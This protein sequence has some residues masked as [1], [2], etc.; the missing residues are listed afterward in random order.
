LRFPVVLAILVAGCGGQKTGP[1]AG[2]AAID[3]AGTD[4]AGGRGWFPSNGAP[5]GEVNSIVV[6]PEFPNVIYAG[7]H[8]VYKS[9][10]AG[11]HWTALDIPS[12]GLELLQDL[13]FAPS[14]PNTMYVGGAEAGIWKSADRGATWSFSDSGF[15]IQAL[16]VDPTQ[17]DTV[18]AGTWEGGEIN[19]VPAG[20]LRKSED[21]GKTFSDPLVFVGAVYRIAVDPVDPAT[22][23]I[24]TADFLYKSTDG[25]AH[26]A[27]TSAPGYVKAI[28]FD[29]LDP[30]VVYAS[31]GKGFS[32][33]DD[34]GATWTPLTLPGDIPVQA[35][36]AHP[37]MQGI[38]YFG[39][40]CGGNSTAEVF[41]SDDGGK[42]SGA[43]SPV[44]LSVDGTV[45]MAIDAR[46]PDVVYAARRGI[47]RSADAGVSWAH[48]GKGINDM[49]L[50][51]IAIDPLAPSTVYANAYFQHI[52]KSTDDG[53]SWTPIATPAVGNRLVIDPVTPSRLYAFRSRLQR[54]DDGGL[55]FTNADAG[56]VDG[57]GMQANVDDMAIVAR[58][59][60]TLYAASDAG[61]FRSADGASSWQRRSQGLPEG[62]TGPI[63]AAHDDAT[64]IYLWTIQGLFVG[65]DAADGWS[66]PPPGLQG[67]ATALVVDPLVGATAYAATE[68]GV[69]RTVD[70]GVHWEH[71]DHGLVGAGSPSSAV[72]LVVD[73]QRSG[74]VYASITTTDDAG[75]NRSRVFATIDG[76]ASWEPRNHGFGSESALPMNPEALAVH[77]RDS[78]ILYASVPG[79]GVFKTFNGGR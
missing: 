36:A 44:G 67:Q 19:G 24:G 23:Y 30:R 37:T 38:V 20:A 54:S 26:V 34:G 75:G 61:V 70:A 12:A 9:N 51:T 71:A 64:T 17:P 56:I 28:A 49:F 47:L 29:A 8:G 4:D 15:R 58:A 78:D 39:T 48:V 79:A 32:R 43:V 21:G 52:L 77:P 27:P 62:K 53:Q 57:Q 16:A 33:S 14:S 40:C 69:F 59:P 7:G 50:T 73:P 22:L 10:D 3:A 31:S 45:S 74:A 66:A 5:V 55:S 42:T 18:Y 1:A 46:D 25:G 60:M 65:R 41:R 76:G 6:D 2:D 72:R 13:T 68:S 63:A 35:I 11:A